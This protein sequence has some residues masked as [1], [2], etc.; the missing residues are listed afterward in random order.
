MHRERECA[1][2][3]MRPLSGTHQ[4]DPL[5]PRAPASPQTEHDRRQAQIASELHATSVRLAKVLVPV[6]FGS[7]SLPAMAFAFACSP[8]VDK[9]PFVVICALTSRLLREP[10]LLTPGQFQVL[11]TGLGVPALA[12]PCL[13]SLLRSRLYSARY[14]GTPVHGRR[15]TRRTE[16]LPT[17]TTP[18]ED[19]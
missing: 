5:P 15:R 14:R 16:H 12:N 19:Q 13:P 18:A 10:E 7:N 8:L 3:T 4:P 17:E 6:I 1:A 9:V 11:C 2:G